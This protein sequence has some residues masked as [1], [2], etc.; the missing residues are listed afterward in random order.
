MV[1]RLTVAYMAFAQQ[2]DEATVLDV[3]EGL[4]ESLHIHLQQISKPAVQP[5]SV[6]F[7][8]RER[9]LKRSEYFVFLIEQNRVSELVQYVEGLLKDSKRQRAEWIV[10]ILAASKYK[11]DTSV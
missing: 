4:P 3:Y 10:R 8:K 7:F 11:A 2:H 5:D 1:E 9:I 6:P